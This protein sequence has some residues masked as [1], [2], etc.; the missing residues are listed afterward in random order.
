MTETTTPNLSGVAETLLIPLYFRAREAQR[1]DALIRDEKAVALVARI[2]YDFS[3]FKFDKEDEVALILRNREF[4]RY[5]Q[6]F[7]KRH[8]DGVVVHIGCGLDSRFER[9]D[10][11]QVEWYDLD[12]PEVIDLRRKLLGGEGDRYHHLPYSAFDPAWLTIVST[13]RPRRFLFIAEGVFTYFEA[14]QIQ[15]LVLALRERFSGAELVCDAF[16]PWL[17]RVNNIKVS[18]TKIGA[19][20]HW[21]L[22]RSQDLEKWGEGI[23]MLDEWSYFSRPEPRLAHVQWMR[24][25]SF[26]AKSSRIVHYRLGTSSP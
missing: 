11:G 24:F 13:Q 26:L 2:N 6:D 8:P 3:K 17:V 16:M 20:Y 19:R 9:V 23:R 21:G 1:P 4:D 18:R 22:Q 12:V 10:N 7:L 25:V 15:A 5:A 14:F